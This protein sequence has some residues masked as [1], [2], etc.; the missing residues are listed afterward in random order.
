M[1]DDSVAGWILEQRLGR[2]G[3]GEVWRVHKQHVGHVRAM[4]LIPGT[5]A[6]VMASW[7]HEIDRL[8]AL[9][10][11]NI[12]RFYD[13][14][15][16]QERGRH[17]G[18]GW[19]VTELCQRSLK[20][21]LA[22][23]QPGHLASHTVER[24]LEDMLAALVALRENGLVHRDIKPGNILLATDSV[25]WKLCD[26][27]TA[28]LVPLDGSSLSTAII[29]TFPYMSAAAHRGRQDHAADLYALAVTIHEALCGKL[30]HDRPPGMTDSEY[31]KHILDSPPRVSPELS[32]RWEAIVSSLAGKVGQLEAHDVQERFVDGGDDFD[33]DESVAA[34]LSVGDQETRAADA[35]AE[36]SE[37]D[38]ARL[39]ELPDDEFPDEE[40][41]S[42][43]PTWRVLV[44][45]IG[46]KRVLGVLLGA[47]IGWGLFEGLQ[48]MASQ[49]LSA[50]DA[51]KF[52]AELALATLLSMVIVAVAVVVLPIMFVV[53]G[54][55]DSFDHAGDVVTG[56]VTE[57]PWITGLGVGGWC[58]VFLWLALTS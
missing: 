35:R 42:D 37:G 13:A 44:A 51:V 3:F 2:G 12:V 24:L 23:R 7:R 41:L 28:R 29:G 16:V 11:P 47:A 17:Q 22:Q 14:G 4:K 53:V 34:T 5:D 50:G 21:E 18:D 48:W 39:E 54:V 15:I 40:A 1:A 31:I 25:T 30:L 20:D 58:I 27:G 36:P 6:E 19:I 55:T 26:F 33:G 32:S 56:A 8:E 49:D 45:L 43:V 9:A 10:H 38:K 46:W 57:Q 52:L